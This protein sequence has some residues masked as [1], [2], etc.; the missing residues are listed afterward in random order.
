MLLR[1]ISG[2]RRKYLFFI[3]FIS[4]FAFGTLLLKYPARFY[5]GT[6]NKSI[7]AFPK[8][9]TILPAIFIYKDVKTL[10]W[11]DQL[12]FNY[13]IGDS[14]DYFYEDK[15]RLRLLRHSPGNAIIY[16]PPFIA[17]HYYCLFRNIEPSGYAPPYLKA[18]VLWKI[19]LI[20]I[21]LLFSF[22]FLSRYFKYETAFTTIIVFLFTTP[23][24]DGPL[25]ESWFPYHQFV[26]TTLLLISLDS[27]W[28]RPSTL[29]SSFLG[30]AVFI[31]TAMDLNN[32]LFLAFI[33]FWY[34]SPKPYHVKSKIFHFLKHYRFYSIAIAGFIG[35]LLIHLAYTRYMLESFEFYNYDGRIFGYLWSN[36]QDSL[37]NIGY[38]LI[39]YVPVLL[40][41]I[42]GL[43]FLYFQHKRLFYFSLISLITY[44]IVVNLSNVA[45]FSRDF[46]NNYLIVILPIMMIPFATLLQRTLSKFWG[47]LI[48]G[49]FIIVSG[50]YTNWLIFH[51]QNGTFIPSNE[52]TAEY[53]LNV[54]GRE[55]LSP[56]NIKLL[57]TEIIYNKP[58]TDSLVLI[59]DRLQ[60]CLNKKVQYTRRWESQIDAG[61]YKHVR[62]RL[63]AFHESNQAEV[64][65]FAQM[66]ISM[67]ENDFNLKN[68][69]IRVQRFTKNN[70]WT[71]VWI[72][73]NLP[74]EVTKIS[75]SIWNAEN[76]ERICFR[77]IEVY[78]Y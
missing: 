9:Y 21:G 38:G 70:E 63:E 52:M 30:G 27:F 18:L 75:A 12:A 40:L 56:E 36:F 26:A 66:L 7:A 43:F 37:T 71:S 48:T 39:L 17:A 16:L 4:L 64:W 55:D 33:L 3:I 65:N 58:I 2:Q 69:M 34:V 77:R 72:D 29:N 35:G 1:D 25:S 6:E 74:K 28:K 68:E 78:V 20:I 62:F 19:S 57:D 44:L 51:K 5:Q 53:F 22:I 42:P 32:A 13:K 60:Y 41:L 23:L 14:D 45:S 76:K 11:F 67:Y 50:F 10:K 49:I 47:S 73:A 46:G 61:K 59:K 24:L 31:L 54:V 15:S 8:D